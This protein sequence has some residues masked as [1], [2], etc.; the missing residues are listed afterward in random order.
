MNRK[1]VSPQAFV[2]KTNH[3][4]TPVSSDDKIAAV[5]FCQGDKDVRMRKVL[6]STLGDDV[7]E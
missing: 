3:P 5:T 4:M 1:I 2:F 7:T 6:D